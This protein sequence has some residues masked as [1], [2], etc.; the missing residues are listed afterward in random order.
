MATPQIKCIKPSNRKYSTVIQEAKTLNSFY[1]EN[2]KINTSNRN[3]QSF[4][5]SSNIVSEFSLE[6]I[7]NERNSNDE[8]ELNKRF[9]ALTNDRLNEMKDRMIRYL[10]ETEER[11]EDK[12]DKYI[13]YIN[14]YILQ[15][16]MKISKILEENSENKI[17]NENEKEEKSKKNFVNYLDKNIFKQIEY[18]F[19]IHDNI[20]AVIE[21]QV[22]LLFGFLDE[23]KLIFERN[24]LEAFIDQ[25]ADKIMQAWLFSKINFEKLN[26]SKLIS[27][28]QLSDI[29]KKYLCKQSENK[30][31]SINI[32]KK[33]KDNF[34]IEKEFIQ[35]N[36]NILQK[37]KFFK[38][39]AD[40]FEQI[41]NA[42]FKNKS[43]DR[44]KS[45]FIS[46]CNNLKKPEFFKINYPSLEKLS[47]NMSIL[48]C[49]ILTNPAMEKLKA[50]KII[51]INH[52]Q[53]NDKNLNDF[54]VFL[55]QKKNLQ[56][57]L[58]SL[59]FT[60]NNLT[61]INMKS[62]L[63]Q[64]AFFPNLTE[65]NLEK[66]NIYDFLSD[67]F[68]ALPS[69]QLLNLSS[70]NISSFLLF[71][72]IKEKRKELK[73]LVVFT[74]N[75]FITNNRENN[76]EYRQYFIN[77]ISKCDYDIKT[78]SLSMMFNRFNCDTLS[79]IV[80]SSAS[81]ISLKKLNLSY[82]GLS[83]K[84]IISFLKTN[85]GL[86]SLKELNLSNNFIDNSFFEEYYSTNA[87]PAINYELTEDNIMKDVD[88][89]KEEG[90]L[91]EKLFKIDLSNNKFEL[92]SIND[93]ERFSR[94]LLLHSNL[95]KVKMQNNKFESDFYKL[96][97]DKEDNENRKSINNY[98]QLFIQKKI[99]IFFKE[100]YGFTII[101]EIL[102]VVNYKD[103]SI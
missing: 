66:N 90:F 39:Q 37:I 21:D 70:N 64:D 26:L 44:L 92:N 46:E 62:I 32:G 7:N 68:K 72:T 54:F 57:A 65:L 6:S 50:L 71:S 79:D 73:A 33:G 76:N 83:T 40:D 45:I 63:N 24:P 28:T 75:L 86:L 38:L 61:F 100:K 95:R 25:N 99:K 55:S 103:K 1:F 74:N 78:L 2:I 81:K 29:F 91:L 49:N 19:E 97:G 22:N 30:F 48:N 101:P 13:E 11:L 56:K 8:G 51:K 93:Y 82:C 53:L 47:I 23:F 35:D 34:P 42:K 36:I 43:A 41:F 85:F 88:K 67:N 5:T 10:K 60:N 59:S 27:N 17:I 102:D 16:E 87:S 52:C 3:K 89:S 31:C 20:K 94:F 69:L 58:T 98:I 9:D 96:W 15:R 4:N 84:S 14:G 77:S 18:I 12:Y 80:F